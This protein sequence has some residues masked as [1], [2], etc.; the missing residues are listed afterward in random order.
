MKILLLR[1]LVF[2]PSCPGSRLQGSGGGNLLG[3]SGSN[4]CGNKALKSASLC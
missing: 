2:S 3:V 1:V 4:V